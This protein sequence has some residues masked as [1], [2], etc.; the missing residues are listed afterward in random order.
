[1]NNWHAHA[2]KDTHKNEAKRF[3]HYWRKN[4]KY[5]FIYFIFNLFNLDVNNYGTY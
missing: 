1:M 2:Q 5:I 4:P 3:L